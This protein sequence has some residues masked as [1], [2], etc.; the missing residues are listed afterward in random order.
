MDIDV[1]FRQQLSS[2]IENNISFERWF[3]GIRFAQEEGKLRV[4]SSEKHKLD[5]IQKNY[6]S[7][8]RQVGHSIFEEPFDVEFEKEPAPVS[9]SL[10]DAEGIDA[11]ADDAVVTGIELTSESIRSVRRPDNPPA[12]PARPRKR[13]PAPLLNWGTL[14]RFVVGRSNRI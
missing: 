4:I 8:I 7:K 9:G 10:F 5:W 13:A 14:D 3:S 1:L 6:L 12:K 11:E 2:L